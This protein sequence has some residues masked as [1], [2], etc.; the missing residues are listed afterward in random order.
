MNTKTQSLSTLP[1]NLGN[2]LQNTIPT[3]SYEEWQSDLEKVPV[4]HQALW[5]R[6]TLRGKHML[7]VFGR[8]FFPHI[9]TGT[10][11]VP[12]CHIDLLHEMNRREDGAILFPRGFAKTTWEKIDTIHDIEYELEPVILYI[13]NT[14]TEAQFHF[15]SI[16]TALRRKNRV[17]QS[18]LKQPVSRKPLQ[19]P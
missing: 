13:G 9:I 16:K 10:D 18:E 11:P 5:I 19:A 7:P 6:E 8:Y 4:E 14:M 2:L 12:D 3:P 1:P 15:E 17:K